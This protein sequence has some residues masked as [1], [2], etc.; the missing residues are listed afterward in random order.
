MIYTFYITIYIFAYLTTD[1]RAFIVF[2]NVM[3]WF[4]VLGVT[5][6]AMWCG[7]E[8][9]SN[10]SSNLNIQLSPVFSLEPVPCDSSSSLTTLSNRYCINY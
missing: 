1:H 7:V 6:T 2:V 8:S 10:S 3:S 5:K 4:R 9:L